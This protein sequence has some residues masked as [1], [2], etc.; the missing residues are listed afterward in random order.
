M[1]RKAVLPVLLR[2]RAGRA[3]GEVDQDR[4]LRAG[5][6]RQRQ[7]VYRAVTPKQTMAAS[8]K[9]R[10][11]LY[12]G[13]GIQKQ[14]GSR[15]LIRS[16]DYA[17]DDTRS[18]GD[19]AMGLD[20]V[21]KEILHVVQDDTRS[22]GDNAMGLKTADKISASSVGATVHWTARLLRLSS[23]P[24]RFLPQAVIGSSP[25]ATLGMTPG[26]VPVSRDSGN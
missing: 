16:L 14:T 24:M 18:A 11:S 20:T 3:R 10:S 25:S 26:G 22:A 12:S 1:R 19:N 21:P 13:T 23:E 6:Q 2:R 15:L 7:P 4:I 9:L 17:R 8:E 5:Q